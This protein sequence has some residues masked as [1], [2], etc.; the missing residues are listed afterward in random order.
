[1][2]REKMI[3]LTSYVEGETYGLLGPQLAASI[4]QEESVYDCIV[5][6]VTREDDKSLLE[7]ALQEYFGNRRPVIG[8]SYLAGRTDLFSLAGELKAGGVLT[9]L[10]GPQADV[11]FLGEK[12]RQD[13]PHYFQGLSS[14]FSMALHGPAEQILPFLNDPIDHGTLSEP[15]L[16]NASSS[17]DER[18]LTKIRWDNLY[19]LSRGRL[20]PLPVATAQVLQQIGCPHA[21]QMRTIEID[22]PAAFRKD[23]KDKVRLFLKG[24]SFCDVAADKG[25][26]GALRLDAVLEQI[27]R[28]PDGE[29]GRKIPFELINENAVPGLPALLA[30][31][32]ANGIHL[33]QINLTL[34]ADWFVLG[35]KILRESLALAA[36]MGVRILLGSVGFESFD[37]RILSNLHKGLDSET[38]MRAVKLMR[39]LKS[40]FARQWAYSRQEGAVHGFI[41][42]TPWDTAETE[43]NNRRIISLYGLLD[44]VLPDH[45]VPLIIHHASALGDWAREIEERENIQFKREGSTVGWWQVGDRFI[46]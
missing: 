34:R 6:A 28:L 3:I 17:W 27:Q 24:C 42:P 46:I 2:K 10:A 25:Y 13:H 36:T 7:K 23:E 40:D 41:H 19:R 43:S 18:F 20:I 11:D 30:G 22:Y 21:S 35:E 29:D 14:C 4:I 9:I 5:V 1:M 26:H 31:V 12:G 33:S 16:F 44:D 15:G 32:G 45:S 38:N 39:E 37:D 8:F